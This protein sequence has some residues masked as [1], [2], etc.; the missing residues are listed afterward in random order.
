MKIGWSV[1]FRFS[2]RITEAIG[3]ER[4]ERRSMHPLFVAISIQHQTQFSQRERAR[5]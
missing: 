4:Q 5:V 3:Y 1:G 2:F